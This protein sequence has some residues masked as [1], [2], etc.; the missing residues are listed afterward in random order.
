M[1]MSSYQTIEFERVDAV[2]W[3][4]LNRPDRLNAFSILMWHELRALGRELAED[5]ELRALIN[6]ATSRRR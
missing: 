5:P 1:N 4:R 6:R 3:L 2:G